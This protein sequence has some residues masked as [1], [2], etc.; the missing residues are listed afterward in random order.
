M[1]KFKTNMNMINKIQSKLID[2]LQ[3]KERNNLQKFIKK[4]KEKKLNQKTESIVFDLP[5]YDIDLIEIQKI[6][7][8]MAIMNAVEEYAVSKICNFFDSKNIILKSKDYFMMKN[9]K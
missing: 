1:I 2:Y 5:F 6:Y 7:P 4:I 3:T 8:N 9:K